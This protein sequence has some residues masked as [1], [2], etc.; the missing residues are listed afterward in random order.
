LLDHEEAT[1]RDAAAQTLN[2]TKDKDMIKHSHP[3]TTPEH[4]AARKK[5]W[6]QW[7]EENRESFRRVPRVESKELMESRFWGAPVNNCCMSIAIESPD[8]RPG[9]TVRIDVLLNILPGDPPHRALDLDTRRL[10]G[11]YPFTPVILTGEGKTVAPALTRPDETEPPPP[12]RVGFFNDEPPLRRTVVLPW[13]DGNLLT[14]YD[15]AKREFAY[16][17]LPPG[18]YCLQVRYFSHG[19]RGQPSWP[20]RLLSNV[21]TFRILPPAELPQKE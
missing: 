12:L 15:T 1:I 13:T 21:V 8:V 18:E 20:K 7:W 6:E 14:A 4:I 11:N 9:R 5:A 16:F 2:L 3:A 19:N 17:N 10:G